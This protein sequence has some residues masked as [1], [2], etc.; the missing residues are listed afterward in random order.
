MLIKEG[1]SN[2]RYIFI[3][4]VLAAIIGGGSLVLLMQKEVPSQFLEITKPQV[5][6]SEEVPPEEFPADETV[7][8]QTYRSEQLGYEI[9]YPLDWV[10]YDRT[11]E[12]NIRHEKKDSDLKE[13]YVEMTTSK[14]RIVYI[15]EG[16]PEEPIVI[17][18]IK[19]SRFLHNENNPG[20]FADFRTTLALLT[21][22]DD[23]QY[24]V[25]LTH[26]EEFEIDSSF[27]PILST[28]RFV[29]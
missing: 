11:R 22:I 13:I 15:R 29:E 1:K 9:K 8:W 4:I 2:L 23:R 26:N 21:S 27:L 16:E 19:W 6:P 7:N 10:L 14:E 25:R 3:V 20:G 28:F 5:K 24:I 18:G 17:G 12:I